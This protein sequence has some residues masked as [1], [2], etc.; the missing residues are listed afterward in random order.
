MPIGLGIDLNLVNRGG[1]GAGGP[2]P[3]TPV[4]DARVFLWV[5]ADG[6]LWQDTART[7]AAVADADPVGAWDD[8]SA[9][10]N[11]LLRVNNDARR[12]TLKLAIKNGRPV[13]RFDG[14]D[15]HLLKAFTCNQ[16]YT[17]FAIILHRDLQNNNHLM[18]DGATD[19]TSYLLFSAAN[20]LRMY[21]GV[22]LNQPGVT[23]N[24]IWYIAR[25][26]FNGASS[27]IQLNAGT[28][29][30]GDA[31]AANLAGIQVGAQGMASVLACNF[32]LAELLVY[33]TAL[34][35]PDVVDVFTYL[36]GRWAVY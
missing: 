31:G 20:T 12:P 32:D 17:R 35:D 2:P 19:D 21:G 7:V 13:V 24:D 22:A 11:H 1:G 25:S 9:N 30:T 4:G 23:S 18:L 14:V 27:K 26:T 34:S 8:G 15:D 16:P 33:N 36:N 29:T 5:K 6:V 10:A 28:V 3:Y